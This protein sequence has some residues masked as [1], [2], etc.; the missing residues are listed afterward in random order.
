[1]KGL[2][3]MTL[4]EITEAI[5]ALID[6]ET[7]EL[8]DYDAFEALEIERKEKIEGTAL[9]VKSLEA[10]AAAIRAEEKAL[11]ERRQSKEKKA[12]R[13]REYLTQALDTRSVFETPRVHISFRGSASVSIF[14]A[15][16][17]YTWAQAQPD[18]DRYFT[19]QEPKPNKTEIKKAI[20]DGTVPGAEIITKDNIQIK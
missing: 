6:P 13:L 15:D 8:L 9:F 3:E 20:S 18:P 5:E 14:D 12:E 16:K 7:G 17:L 11:A 1:M 4:Y 19:P 10:D 2:T